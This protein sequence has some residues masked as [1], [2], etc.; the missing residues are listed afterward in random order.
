MWQLTS[1]LEELHCLVHQRRCSRIDLLYAP[2]LRDREFGIY[3]LFEKSVWGR[4]PNSG[5]TLKFC[6]EAGTET[7]K[8]LREMAGLTWLWFGGNE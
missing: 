4:F 1:H 8:A 6:Q 2:S 3:R 7:K 5:L